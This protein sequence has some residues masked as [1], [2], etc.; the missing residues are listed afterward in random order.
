MS[1]IKLDS[2]CIEDIYNRIQKIINNFGG[3]PAVVRA[4]GVKDQTWRKMLDPKRV[5]K[6]PPEALKLMALAKIGNCSIEYILTGKDDVKEKAQKDVTV[7]VLDLAKISA[8]RNLQFILESGNEAAVNA[9]KQSLQLF[10]DTV[11][12]GKTDIEIPKISKKGRKVA[13]R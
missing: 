4:T 6:E 3:I 5:K 2:I 11:K 10:V 13:R 7:D 1:T 8:H 9:A 12:N